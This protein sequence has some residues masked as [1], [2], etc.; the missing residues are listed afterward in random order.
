MSNIER[1]AVALEKLASQNVSQSNDAEQV[2]AGLHFFYADQ[3]SKVMESSR[4]MFD[5][6]KA[7]RALE[8][9]ARSTG[10]SLLDNNG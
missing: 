2:A 1:I 5:I 4:D 7:L 10:R 8:S 9:M 6:V 3:I